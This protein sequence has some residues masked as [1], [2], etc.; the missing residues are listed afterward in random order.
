MERVGTG[1]GKG[2]LVIDSESGGYSEMIN[3]V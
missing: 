3:G 1:R 2:V